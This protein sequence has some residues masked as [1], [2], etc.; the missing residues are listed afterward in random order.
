[1][2][3]AG[4]DQGE[5]DNDY[6][7]MP[8]S[9]KDHVGPLENAF[10][11]E[12]RLL[13]QGVPAEGREGSWCLS[14]STRTRSGAFVQPQPGL[15]E[16]VLV[17]RESGAQGAPPEEE[18]EALCGAPGRLP[19][20]ALPGPPAQLRSH[21]WDATLKGDEGGMLAGMGAGGICR[22][23]DLSR[24]R[25]CR[26]AFSLV[27][28]GVRCASKYTATLSS[29]PC[30]TEVGHLTAAV[31]AKEPVGEGYELLIESLAGM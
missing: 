11:C 14:R 20:P 26:L 8:V 17:A 15:V 25:A 19:P 10:P 7:L 23:I 21:R 29:L 18:R 28:S 2:I 6:F 24:K 13:P 16:P 4:K 30:L 31:A 27:E 9:I 12:N 1:M 3:V 5:V 22:H